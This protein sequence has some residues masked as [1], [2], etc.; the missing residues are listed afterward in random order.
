MRAFFGSIGGVLLLVAVVVGVTWG[1][2]GLYRWTA[3]AMRDAQREVFEESQSFVHGKSQHLARLRL[4]YETAQTPAHKTALRQVI[5][6][7]ASTVDLN[8]ID[9]GLRAFIQGL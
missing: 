5:L 6:S 2:I 3:P 9:P 4:E 7:E 8:Q 1:S